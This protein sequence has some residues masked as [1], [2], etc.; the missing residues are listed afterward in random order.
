MLTHCGTTGVIVSIS[1]VALNRRKSLNI[2]RNFKNMKA[3]EWLKILAV[4]WSLIIYNNF[5]QYRLYVAVVYIKQVLRVLQWKCRTLNWIL[6]LKGRIWSISWV[7]V[8][9]I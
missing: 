9:N 2:G 3:E 4:L 7:N 5:L 1:R 8:K 6:P